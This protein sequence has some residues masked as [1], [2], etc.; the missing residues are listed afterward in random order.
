MPTRCRSLPRSPTCRHGGTRVP[1]GL[2][3]FEIAV[4]VILG[5]QVTV[6]A[7]RTLARRLVDA[8][9]EPIDTPF[10]DLTRL[11]PS[12]DRLAAATAEQIGRLGIVRQRVKALQALAAE[13]AAGRLT[14]N[15][16]RRWRPR[17]MRCVHCPASASGRCN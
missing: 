14:L 17:S 10:T 1:N 12:P 5:Q 6:A 2:D 4:R 3:G 7:A 15:A 16:A 11:F 9:G 8:L 13:V